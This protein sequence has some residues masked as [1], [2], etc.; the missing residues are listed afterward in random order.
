M[1]ILN[2]NFTEY[3]SR[4]SI[5]RVQHLEFRSQ[6]GQRCQSFVIEDIKRLHP[7]F[8]FID[9]FNALLVI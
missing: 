7:F 9:S 2:H 5:T 4:F 6:D 1:I 8:V 3:A